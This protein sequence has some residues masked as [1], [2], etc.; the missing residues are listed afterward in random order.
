MA[1]GLVR[2]SSR[3][4]PEQPVAQDRFGLRALLHSE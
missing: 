1:L 2:M 4:S 3:H